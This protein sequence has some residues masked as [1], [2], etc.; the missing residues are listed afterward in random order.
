M[1]DNVG[2]ILAYGAVLEPKKKGDIHAEEGS[3]TKAA[4]GASN[5]GVSVK[6]SSDGDLTVF[7]LGKEF[8]RV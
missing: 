8:I 7:M 4:K 6:V 2:S 5:Y 3:R 1:L